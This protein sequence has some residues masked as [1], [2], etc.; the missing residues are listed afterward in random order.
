MTAVRPLI[1]QKDDFSSGILTLLS[2]CRV[3]IATPY[4]L[5]LEWRRG[6]RDLYLSN[7]ATVYAS[8]VVIE[9]FNLLFSPSTTDTVL[10]NFG[11]VV[12]WL[13]AGVFYWAKPIE[14]CFGIKS[15][16]SDCSE[17]SDYEEEDDPM[18][19]ALALILL[20]VLIYIG[21]LSIFWPIIMIIDKAHG[22]PVKNFVE[23]MVI[24]FICLLTVPYGAFFW[25]NGSPICASVLYLY[26]TIAWIYTGWQYDET[27]SIPLAKFVPRMKTT[28][29]A[30]GKGE[31]D[32]QF[33]LGVGVSFFRGS[34]GGK[35]AL[36]G[37]KYRIQIRIPSPKRYHFWHGISYHYGYHRPLYC[38]LGKV[39][40]CCP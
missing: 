18:T 28:Q 3:I 10:V 29:I 23:G 35:S 15:E 5:F 21:I 6:E 8:L 38:H 11:V 36:I 2:I 7:F 39:P 20:P 19:I 34:V 26:V 13:Y 30:F 1:V 37:Q 31:Q 4:Y 27:T 22:K 14:E 17:R 25:H 12:I 24:C 33:D 9:V 40:Q 32:D 16:E